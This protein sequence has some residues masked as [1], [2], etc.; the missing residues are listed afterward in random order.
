MAFCV[1]HGLLLSTE[2]RFK[3]A[4]TYSGTWDPTPKLM[5]QMA[6]EIPMFLLGSRGC[7]TAHSLV[8]SSLCSV[9]SPALFCCLQAATPCHPTLCLLLWKLCSDL[10][11]GRSQRLPSKFCCQSY[12]INGFARFIVSSVHLGLP[13]PLGDGIMPQQ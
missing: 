9:W 4:V 2:A 7:S 10:P 12:F 11:A 3:E 13:T 6:P 1:S 8:S 5:E